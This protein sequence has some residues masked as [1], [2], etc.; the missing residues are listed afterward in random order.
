M[1][2]DVN[3]GAFAF[4]AQLIAGAFAIVNVLDETA[5]WIGL[6]LAFNAAGNLLGGVRTTRQKPLGE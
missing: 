3:F 2:R 1:D 4:V 6:A 5:A